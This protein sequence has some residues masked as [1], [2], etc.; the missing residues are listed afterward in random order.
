MSYI[1]KD[2]DGCFF[3]D[4]SC[5]TE[6]NPSCCCNSDTST[7]TATLEYNENLARWYWLISGWSTMSFR[8]KLALFTQYIHV[9]RMKGV[10]PSNFDEELNNT[11]SDTVYCKCRD[12]LGLKYDEDHHGSPCYTLIFDAID[13]DLIPD[14]N[15]KSEVSSWYNKYV[16]AN[17][18]SCCSCWVNN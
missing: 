8:E 3:N 14:S 16:N 4:V 5:T 13:I 11:I 6:V 1:E 10:D 12:F 17:S 2:R 15:I 9:F 7:D 18:S